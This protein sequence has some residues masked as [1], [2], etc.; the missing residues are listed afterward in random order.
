MADLDTLEYDTR[1]AS[2]LNRDNDGFYKFMHRSF[3]E[4][5]VARCCVR[6]LKRDARGIEYW[7]IRWFD[8]EIAGFISEMLQQKKNTD[9]IGI[10][11]SLCLSSSKRTI[12][13]NALHIL[14]LIGEMQFQT[15]VGEQLFDQLIERGENECGAVI[16]RQ[17]CRIIAKFGDREKAE[18]LIRRIIELVSKDK[19]QNRDN[20]NTYL[21][22]YYGQSAACE[23]LLKHLSTEIPKYDRALHIYVLGEIGKKEHVERLLQLVRKWDN[24][25]HIGMAHDAVR[26][27]E[28][29][30]N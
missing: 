28:S 19:V 23:A 14:S 5:F 21:S 15:Y 12:L 2:F 24:T 16:L 10:L 3:M 29:R 26:R 4:Y 20:N 27:I 17:Y 8:K 22:Y 7:D 6:A 11:A 25:D 13:W 30:R 9:K 1:N 18:Q